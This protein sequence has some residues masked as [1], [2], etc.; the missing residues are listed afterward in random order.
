MSE[1]KRDSQDQNDNKHL[2]RRPF[3]KILGA[4]LFGHFVFLNTKGRPGE[5]EPHCE[6]MYFDGC[7]E[8]GSPPVQ[9]QCGGVGPG[10][11]YR[12]ICWEHSQGTDPDKCGEANAGGG[13]IS[14]HCDGGSVQPSSPD[15][16]GQGNSSGEPI[17]DQCEGNG[18]DPDHCG[19]NQHGGGK[20]SD[21]CD[22]SIGDEDKCGQDIGGTI[23][24]DTCAGSN[25]SDHCMDDDENGQQISDTCNPSADP[26]QHDP[27][28]CDPRENESDECKPPFDVDACIVMEQS[29]PDEC[30]PELVALGDYDY[31]IPS[32]PGDE[33]VCGQR[34]KLY[35][36]LGSI[37]APDNEPP[38]I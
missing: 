37:P 6:G 18:S 16:C 34:M 36:Q 25:N 33:V 20:I 24:P 27:D 15:K 17:S 3:L 31:C 5:P 12:D 28:K 11:I 26:A 30:T 32:Q 14:D 1:L 22:S 23:V 35:G 4:G 29:D 21:S 13:T 8:Q 7:D 10:H 9:D 2:S 19:E 38:E